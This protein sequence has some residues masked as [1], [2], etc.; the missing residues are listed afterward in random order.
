[1][2]SSAGEIE[3]A[4]HTVLGGTPVREAAAA[5]SLDP[6]SLEDAT[7]LYRSAGRAALD[8]STQPDW[9]QAYVQF[10]D[11]QTAEQSVITHL[12]PELQQAEAEGSIAAWWFVRKFPCWRFRIRSGPSAAPDTV[13]T[14]IARVLDAMVAHSAADRWWQSIYEP[15]TYVLG[16]PTSMDIAHGLFHADSRELLTYIS[17]HTAE[18]TNHPP[19]GRK[20]LSV[21][22]L[23]TLMRGAGQEWSEQC[24][25][26][27]RVERSRPLPPDTPLDR[28]R[29]MRPG[30]QKLL[31]LDL[32]PKSDLL[33][34]DGP[35]AS[36]STWF[37][38]FA[39]GGRQLGEAVRTGRVE[40]GIRDIAERHILFHWN[41]MG[42]PQRQQSVVARVARD[43]AF[44]N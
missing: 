11:W 6:T 27:H 21:L 43:A 38:V 5:A 32:G 19:L 26:W 25:I 12:W 37:E 23:S 31:I 41:R 35:L 13:Q 1:M 4:I 39:K 29:A 40:R 16:G 34:G 10:R 30:M 28:L 42:L 3:R 20:E 22:L 33:R 15:E 24:D 9:F 18:K 44:R 8:A 14:L 7:N 36:L 17:R 2:H